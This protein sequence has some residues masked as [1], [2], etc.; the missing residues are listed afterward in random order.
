MLC[1]RIICY[2]TCNVTVVNSP[3]L[4]DSGA[5]TNLKMGGGALIQHKAP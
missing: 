2:M 3:P 4:T 5:G 1:I